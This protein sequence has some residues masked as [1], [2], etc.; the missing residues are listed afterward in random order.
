MSG[1]AI[2][3]NPWTNIAE[4]TV[5][6]KK[7]SISDN[8]I[9]LLIFAGPQTPLQLNI[10]GELGRV[11]LRNIFDPNKDPD[12]IILASMFQAEWL[13][14]EPQFAKRLKLGVDRKTRSAVSPAQRELVDRVALHENLDSIGMDWSLLPLFEDDTWVVRDFDCPGCGR[15]GSTLEGIKLRKAQLSLLQGSLDEAVTA[16]G[17]ANW[18][19]L[20]G[21][22]EKKVK[23]ATIQRDFGLTYEQSVQVISLFENLDFSG[24]THCEECVQRRLRKEVR[25]GTNE[26]ISLPATL[27]FQVLQASG[28]RCHYCGRGSS[29]TPP[30]ELEVDHIVPVAAGGTNELGNLQA[31]CRDCNRG[32]S[33]TEIL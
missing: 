23:P 31:A 33:A 29:S 27:R 1:S 8:A 26:R 28:F 3:F 21:E 5:F 22:L 12:S 15:L 16:E 9:D 10:W 4:S 19:H 13:K 11:A 14:V 24:P 17:L 2:Y 30:V 20:Q 32:K 6:T 25:S 7:E 18:Y